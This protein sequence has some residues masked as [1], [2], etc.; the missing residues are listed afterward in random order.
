MSSYRLV[1]ER[2][3]NGG[4]G[5]NA[6]FEEAYKKLNTAQRKAVDT[7]EG[8]VM[9]LACPGTG[10]TQIAAVRIAN[11]LTKTDTS[12]GSILALTFSDSAAKAMRERLLTLI[13]NDAYYVQIY[14]FH[15][16]CSEVI[17]SNPDSFII[18]PDPQPLGDLERFEIIQSILEKNHFKTIKPAGSIYYYTFALIKI[19]QTLKREGVE[20]KDF[21]K[22][23]SATELPKLP[24]V[25]VVYG[26][27]QL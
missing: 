14:T 7:I 21:D 8:P 24:E 16:F 18:G 27:Y 3:Y 23:I 26:L 1:E 4:M 19:I 2:I 25:A 20:Q 9:V 12:P 15:G 17:R 5:K 11:I 10:K 13:G 22:L 6:K